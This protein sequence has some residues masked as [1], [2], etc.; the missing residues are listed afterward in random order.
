[1]KNKLSKWDVI[2]SWSIWMN[3]CHSCYNYERLQGLGFGHSMMPII[4]K[5]YEVIDDKKEAIKRHTDF[6]NTEPN[7]GTPIHGYIISLEEKKSNGEET[8]NISAIKKGL[9]GSIAGM[10]DSIT[11]TIIT[12]LMLILA[13]Y[14]ALLYNIIGT[15]I[16]TFLLAAY[17]IYISFTG[18]MDGYY[19]GEKAII[20]RIEKSK[21]NYL[22]KVFPIFFSMLLALVIQKSVNS[23]T[24]SNFTNPSYISNLVL[25]IAFCYYILIKKGIKEKYLII[26]SYILAITIFFFM[27]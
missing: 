13:I 12:P 2:K 11:Q 21:H 16:C 3:F 18:W 4:N 17:I 26:S 20:K 19:N 23:L 6:F 14:Y 5:I 7:I 15:V 8:R 27:K 22:F 10:G 1:M 24:C 25:I 9:M